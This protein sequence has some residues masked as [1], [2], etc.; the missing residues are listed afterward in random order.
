MISKLDRIS[1]PAYKKLLEK[2]CHVS[3]YNYCFVDQVVK[4]LNISYFV[5]KKEIAVKV[6]SFD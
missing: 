1:L 3:Y 6:F 2:E 5:E 4:K